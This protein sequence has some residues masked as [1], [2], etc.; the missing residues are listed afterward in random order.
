MR[1]LIV[2]LGVLA[3]IVAGLSTYL[4]NAF[5]GEEKL[6]EFE[7]LARPKVNKVLIAVREIRPG[8]ELSVGNIDWQAWVDG[9]VNSKYIVVT[10]PPD[11]SEESDRQIKNYMGQVARWTFAAGEPITQ[12]KVFK[13]SETSF[14]SGLLRKGMRAVAVPVSPTTAVGGFILPGDYVDV[15][16]THKL[17]GDVEK[18]KRRTESRNK[19]GQSQKLTVVKF[20]TETIVRGV[21]VVAVDQLHDNPEETALVSKT[22]TLEASPKQVEI[23][24]AG[25]AMGSLSLTLRSL[26][27]DAD[28]TGESSYTTDIEVS[29]LLSRLNGGRA[30]NK[31]AS[32]GTKKKASSPSQVIKIYRGGESTTQEITV[33]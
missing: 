6:E 13:P 15:L 12:G 1:I 28:E 5:Y 11:S 30:N 8:D 22:V 24:T 23:L 20:S 7:K 3:L 9:S 2:G 18:E 16:L 17:A 4:I 26:A 21:R 14:M 31:T 32:G 19:S 10:E 29:P 33:R 27:N 25:M